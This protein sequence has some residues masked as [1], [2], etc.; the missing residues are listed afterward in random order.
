MHSKSPN[1]RRS[2]AS[3]MGG[4]C[5]NDRA[6]AFNGR[7]VE[8]VK[9]SA[10]GQEQSPENVSYS[11]A[12]WNANAYPHCHQGIGSH[13]DDTEKFNRQCEKFGGRLHSFA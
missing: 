13:A 3:V 6:A 10:L 12:Q 5:S 8:P 9:I 7:I 4:L 2:E 11:D 1:R